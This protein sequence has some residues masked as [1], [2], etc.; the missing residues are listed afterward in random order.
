MLYL[1]VKNDQWQNDFWQE[2]GKWVEDQKRKLKHKILTIIFIITGTLT[3]LQR[4]PKQDWSSGQDVWIR[5]T[6]A[7]PFDITNKNI[8]P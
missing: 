6:E 3:G 8:G 1:H 7:T 2:E 5:H 4:K